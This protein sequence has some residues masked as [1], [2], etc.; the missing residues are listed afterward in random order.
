[1]KKSLLWMLTAILVFCDPAMA[2][3]SKDD[4]GTP[5]KKEYFPSWNQCE[6][7]T[8]IPL[9]NSLTPRATCTTSVSP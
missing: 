9:T 5:E 1:M 2:S 3:C 7:L 4:A 8:A 6:A